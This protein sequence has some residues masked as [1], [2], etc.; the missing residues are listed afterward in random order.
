M[1]KVLSG[2]GFLESKEDLEDK[3]SENTALSFARIFSGIDGEKVLSHLEAITAGRT[4]SHNATDNE[5]RHLEGKRNLYFYIKTM[6]KN[7]QTNF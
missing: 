2:W 6:I 5:L 3:E 1:K 4:L 7:G